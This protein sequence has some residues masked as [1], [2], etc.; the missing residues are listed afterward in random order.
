MELVE[1]TQSKSK[2][3]SKSKSNSNATQK[4][5]VKWIRKAIVLWIALLVIGL[6]ALQSSAFASSASGNSITSVLDRND[7][8][9]DDGTLWSKGISQW[10]TDRD[11]LMNTPIHH[12]N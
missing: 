9:L 5:R 10:Q 4:F 8:L 1:M 6:I 11:L 7:Y 3:K 2:S 12:F